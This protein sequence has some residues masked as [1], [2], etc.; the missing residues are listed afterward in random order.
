MIKLMAHAQKES[1]EHVNQLKP[2]DVLMGSLNLI[3]AQTM[4]VMIYNAVS[5]HQVVKIRLERKANV[6]MISHVEIATY[7]ML[8]MNLRKT[9][10][11][12][13]A[14]YVTTLNIIP[15]HAYGGGKMLGRVSKGVNVY[16]VT[17]I[18]QSNVAH[19]R[20]QVA[21]LVQN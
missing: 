11:I 3:I 20:C 10:G 7:T 8:G 17:Q 4:Q 16:A 12:L 21:Q 5:N 13:Q 18:Q 6:K 14:V 1:K 9:W 19:M 2:G 15:S